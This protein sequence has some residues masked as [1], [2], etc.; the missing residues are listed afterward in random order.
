MVSFNPYTPE[1]RNDPYPEYAALREQDPVHRS[2]TLQFWVLTRY[3]DCARVLRDEE[4]FSSEAHNATGL[5]AQLQAQ[6]EAQA[7]PISRT[8]L[9][10]DPPE[11]T[12]LRSLVN[13]A[14][15]PRQVERL[16]PHIAEV[17]ESLLDAA[18]ADE[19]F[20][21]IR[22]LAQPLPIII[23]AELLGVPPSER[24]QFKQ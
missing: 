12:R 24:E 3:A 17:T 18:S 16:R 22:G 10:S 2:K 23:I 20:D 8:V 14:F 15:T 19:P 7:G 11:H 6:A 5:I 9:S 4:S 1:F 13:K 21:V